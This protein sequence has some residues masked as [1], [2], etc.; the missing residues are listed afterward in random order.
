MKFAD[1]LET[2]TLETI[3]AGKMTK[4]LALITSIPNPT[5][6]SS[7]GFIQAIR[8]TLEGKLN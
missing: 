5:A 7:E 1:A 4:D 6:L 3:E 8:E 2:A